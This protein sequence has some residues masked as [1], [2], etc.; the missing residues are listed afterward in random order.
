[1][2][3]TV[4]GAESRSVLV[5]RRRADLGA[6]AGLWHIPASGMVEPR[7]RP[8]VRHML[9]R[10]IGAEPQE[11]ARLGDRET[12]AAL[13]DADPALARSDAVMMG[14]VDFGHHALVEFLLT[15]GAD[16]NARASLC[17]RL[18]FVAD[19]TRHDYRDVTPLAWGARFHDQDW[20]SRPAVRLI[21]ERGGH[22]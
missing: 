6:D 15:R 21:A 8:L 20:V 4:P 9:A 14:A 12:L 16:P 3:V 7:G 1:M 18:R 10:G 17:K 2:A 11:F 22:E 5:G 13:I 19:E